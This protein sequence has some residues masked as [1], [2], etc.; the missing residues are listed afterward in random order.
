VIPNNTILETTLNESLNSRATQQN[1]RFTLTVNSPSQ[2]QG[3]V[4]EGHVSSTDQS[5]RLTGRTRMTLNFDQ[6][7]LPDGGSYPFAG[8][9]TSVRNRNGDVLQVDNEGTIQSG[10]QTTQTEERAAIGTGIGAIIGAIAGG[11]KGAA[12]GAILGAGI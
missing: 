11:G 10:N 8:Y 4:I 9:L 12:I 7:R 2:Y 1:D 5:G 6:V 3:A